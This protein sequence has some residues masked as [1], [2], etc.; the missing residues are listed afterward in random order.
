MIRTQAGRPHRLS[1][2][3]LQSSWC[4][5]LFAQF[6]FPIPTFAQSQKRRKQWVYPMVVLVAGPGARPTRAEEWLSQRASGWRRV[7]GAIERCCISVEFAVKPTSVRN[8]DPFSFVFHVISSPSREPCR[9]CWT[10][11]SWRQVLCNLHSW[12]RAWWQQQ[13]GHNDG[14]RFQLPFL[15]SFFPLLSCDRHNEQSE[16]HFVLI[17][18]SLPWLATSA[19]CSGQ[20]TVDAWQEGWHG[21]AK[22]HLI[23]GFT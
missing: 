12:R 15:Q 20:G 11:A 14:K 18:T 6:T 9:G 5:F 22:K 2:D 13:T 17:P 7:S 23:R 1:C 21:S 10:R 3:W 16:K 8:I 4:W 19:W